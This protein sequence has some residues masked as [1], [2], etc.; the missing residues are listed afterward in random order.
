[1]M[2]PAD[3]AIVDEVIVPLLR[4]HPGAEAELWERLSA[5]YGLPD[6]TEILTAAEFAIRHKLHPDTAAR[7]AR[8]G[9]IPAAQKVGREWRIPEDAEVLPVSDAAPR[10]SFVTTA[11]SRKRSRSHN[12][13]SDAMREMARR[14][15]GNGTG[16]TKG[17]T[18]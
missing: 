7:L 11:A 16:N 3:S 1:M 10:W 6:A 8:E 5:K 15:R 13:A 17:G 9:R 12:R 2:S 14:R 4:V 18:T